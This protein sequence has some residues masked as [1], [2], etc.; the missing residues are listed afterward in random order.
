MNNRVQQ[1]VLISITCFISLALQTTALGFQYDFGELV[2]QKNSLYTSISVYQSD[3]VVTLQF[4]RRNAYAVESQ[5][6]NF[7]V[8]LP[9]VSQ[10][11][12]MDKL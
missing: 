7:L 12:T 5:V 1:S 8:N 9:Y 3:S 2:H 10:G 11:K 4:G 6:L